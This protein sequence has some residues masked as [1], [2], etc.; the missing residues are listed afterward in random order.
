MFFQH[1]RAGNTVARPLWHEF[2][3]DQITLEI[4]EQFLWG[5][6]FMISPALYQGQTSVR[7]YIPAGIWYDYFTRQA[8]SVSSDF[9]DIDCPLT[10]IPL[11]V[12]GGLVMPT[13]VKQ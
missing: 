13:Q 5:S 9:L 1:A 2:P 6:S 3:T 12:R 8:V 10:C 4:D 11:H 7:A